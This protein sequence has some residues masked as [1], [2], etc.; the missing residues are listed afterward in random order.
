MK[1]RT[2]VVCLGVA[3]IAWSQS[4]LAQAG[5]AYDRQGSAQM[6]EDQRA[7]GRTGQGLTEGDIAEPRGRMDEQNGEGWFEDEE[8]PGVIDE[9]QEP[10]GRLGEEE[11]DAW[12]EDEEGQAGADKESW[13]EDEEEDVSVGEDSKS[14]D[15]AK[16]GSLAE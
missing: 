12:F 6:Q 14:A 13:F 1:G 15:D 16:A 11:D 4:A 3:L 7:E 10:R 5:G 2:I 8:G 9:G